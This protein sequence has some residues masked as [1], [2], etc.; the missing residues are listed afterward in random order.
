MLLVFFYGKSQL[1]VAKYLHVVMRKLL[2]NF[3]TI[4]VN[5]LFLSLVG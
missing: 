5:E 2:I 4:A 1:F 3:A